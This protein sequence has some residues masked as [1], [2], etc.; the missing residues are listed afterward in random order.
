MRVDDFHGCVE[1]EE[2]VRVL[3]SGGGRKGGL[4]SVKGDRGRRLRE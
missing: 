2:V 1:G 4:Q 3:G